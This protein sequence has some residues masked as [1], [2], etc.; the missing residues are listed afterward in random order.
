MGGECLCKW[1]ELLPRH[2]GK[3]GVA[4]DGEEFNPEGLNDIPGQH[5]QPGAVG[6]LY[7]PLCISQVGIAIVKNMA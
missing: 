7:R 4:L 6:C 1:D 3:K 2:P 5:L